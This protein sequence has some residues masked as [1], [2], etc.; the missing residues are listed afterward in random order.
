M[1]RPRRAGGI[2]AR[3][4]LTLVELMVSA[5]LMALILTA[6]YQCFSAAVAAQR[7]MDPR[8]ETAQSARVILDRMAAE[9]R[10]ACALPHGSAFLGID[11]KVGEEEADSLDFATHHFTPGLA[12]QGDYC[13]ISYFVERDERT[14]LL[15]LCRQQHP[16]IPLET[17]RG[18]TKDVL[19]SGV[20]VLRLEYYD[21]FDWY[22][23]WGETDGGVRAETSRRE[24]S[25]L[26]GLPEAVRITL[27]LEPDPKPRRGTASL[28]STRDEAARPEPPMVFQTVARVVLAATRSEWGGGGSGSGSAAAP[29]GNETPGGGP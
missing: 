15:T 7:L 3:H 28:E 12:G 21:G 24:S 27:G 4:G 22:D 26:S 19:V 1:M 25:N 9:L 2:R 8:L 6:A 10:G 14:G 18:G 11:R 16:G 13:A 23:S 29:G 20:R 17:R 5:A